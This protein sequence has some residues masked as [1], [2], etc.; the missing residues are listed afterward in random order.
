[1]NRFDLGL[2]KYEKEENKVILYFDE[3]RIT[4][5]SY[6]ITFP[7]TLMMEPAECET[8]STGVIRDQSYIHFLLKFA[9][10]AILT[11]WRPLS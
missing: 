7:S 10:F 2:M 11:K 3:V 1:M 8:K 6:H 9:V 5:L 4:D